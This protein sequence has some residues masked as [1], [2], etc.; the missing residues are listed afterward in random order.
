MQDNL[1]LSLLTLQLILGYIGFLNFDAIANDIYNDI[2]ALYNLTSHWINLI[3]K[4]DNWCQ[5]NLHLQM[6]KLK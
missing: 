2:Y 4:K 1:L 3:V 6:T 5:T